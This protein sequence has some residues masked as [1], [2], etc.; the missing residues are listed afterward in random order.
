M[1]NLTNDAINKYIKDYWVGI[2]AYTNP[3]SITK[4]LTIPSKYPINII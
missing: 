4:F 1:C 2:I 3:T